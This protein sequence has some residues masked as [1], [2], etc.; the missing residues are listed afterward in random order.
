MGSCQQLAPTPHITLQEPRLTSQIRIINLRI[1]QPSIIQNLQLRPIR[2]RNIRKVLLITTIHL[3]RVRLALLIP[4][5]VPIGRRERHLDITMAL[6]GRNALEV[7][8]LPNVRAL[9]RVADLADAD[10][11]LAGDLLFLDE[12]RDVRD[13]QAEDGELGVVDLF[14]AVQGGEERALRAC[15]QLSS[16]T[17]FR[18]CQGLGVSHPEHVPTVLAIADGAEAAVR[19][20]LHN[21]ADGLVLELHEAFLAVLLLLNGMALVQ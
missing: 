20:D 4:Q 16:L 17:S 14:H 11:G 9:A 3:L 2:L 18:P 1:P 13:V 10:H 5:M 12:G 8:E 7:L 15:C 19:L 6:L 21:L